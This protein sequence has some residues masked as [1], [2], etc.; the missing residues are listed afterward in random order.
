MYT[1]MFTVRSGIQFQIGLSLPKFQRPYGM[2][3]H[4]EAALEKAG[5]PMGFRCSR[6]GG[7][8]YG[9]VDGHRLKR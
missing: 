4:C 3:A 7:H 1:G 9:L 2:E 8:E 5:W 6:C